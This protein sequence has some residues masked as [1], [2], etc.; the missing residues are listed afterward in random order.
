ML[1]S[2]VCLLTKRQETHVLICFVF[3]HNMPQQTVSIALWFF[4]PNERCQCQLQ[5]DKSKRTEFDF[6][7]EHITK[8]TE[9]TK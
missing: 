7:S 3:G 9:T 2:K 1:V 4:M 5:Q 6:C 8:V